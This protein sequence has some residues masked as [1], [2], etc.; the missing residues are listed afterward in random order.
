MPAPNPEQPAAERAAFPCAH[1]PPANVPRY[2]RFRAEGRPPSACVWHALSYYRKYRNKL[3]A[4]PPEEIAYFDRQRRLLRLLA[5]EDPAAGDASLAM[6]GDLMWIR[7]GWASF[8]AP[9]VLDHMNRY[10]AVLG[11]LETVISPRFRVP[12]LLPDCACFNSDPA[13]LT[14]FRRPDG[15]NTFTALAIANNHALDFR[16]PGAC[17]VRR[18]LDQQQIL[19]SGVRDR[20]DDCPYVTFTVNGIR[21][22]F[23]AATWGLNSARRH[24]RSSLTINTIPD[25]A[26]EGER[27]ADLTELKAAL[28]AMDAEGLDFKIVSLHWGFEYELY[29]TPTQMQVA[30]EIVRA[31]ADVIL[32]SH[33]HVQQPCE[34]CF[35][36]GYETRYGPPGERLAAMS[37]PA[38][39]VLTDAT[40]RPRKALICYSLG[41]FTTAMFTFL[42]RVGLIQGL[43]LRRDPQSGHVDWFLPHAK[44]VYNVRRDPA[45]GQ[46]RLVF[47]KTHVQALEAS[48]PLSPKLRGDLDFLTRHI[49]A[50]L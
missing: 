46:R 20:E 44:L 42:C 13:L 16:D 5:S 4:A 3:R 28:A 47:L 32:G 38:G 19:H 12:R 31:G 25:L 29:P 49:V 43:A 48:G 37:H 15:R 18:F 50:E 1:T 23:Y 33:P 6:V 41:N 11:N 21:I 9:E 7:S 24:A 27:D 36:N 35:L 17:D 14:S 39:C 34:V 40:G 30:R 26:P 45:S 22:G 2:A 8:L 10:D